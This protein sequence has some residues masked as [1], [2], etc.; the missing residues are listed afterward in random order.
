MNESAEDPGARR[1]PRW[2]SVLWALNAFFLAGTYLYYYAPEGHHA[3]LLL[4]RYCSLEFEKN[5]ATYWEGWCFFGVALLAFQ[6]SLAPQ[7]E[8]P[9]PWAW[10][11][12]AALAAGLSLD[13]LGSVHERADVLFAPLEGS[14]ALVP[15]AIPALAIAL[16]TLA[17]FWRSRN[18]RGF[19]FLSSGLLCF[20]L[21]VGQEKLERRLT[22][23]DWAHSV[24]GVLEEGSELVGLYLLFRVVLAP[25]R[26]VLALL[27]E[28]ETLRRLVAPAA[29]LTLLGMPALAYVTFVTREVQ[30]GRGIPAAWIPFAL[31][32]ATAIAAFWLARKAT[33]GRPP[34]ALL[35]VVA[36]AFSADQIM[37]LQRLSNPRLA[38][39]FAEIF[40]LPILGALALATPAFR[41]PRTALVLAALLALD[42]AFLLSG[43]R[44]VP[45]IVDPLQAL[46]ILFIVAGAP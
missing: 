22:L 8:G 20:A 16:P 34:L 35:A 19:W 31:L 46:G 32:N 45:W 11:G 44:L 26:P 18:K 24:R 28:R 23:P 15:L 27:P 7:P 10:R 36:L 12:L 6:R 37:V 3:I 33:R 29:A 43:S 25:G 21:A 42:L 2:E 39:S 1:G 5:L 9:G 30:R 17:G 13:E 38:H 41:T 40:M 14:R 4:L